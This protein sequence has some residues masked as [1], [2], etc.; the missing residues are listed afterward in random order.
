MHYFENTDRLGEG[1]EALNDNTAVIPLRSKR[2]ER[3]QKKQQKKERKRKSR[4]SLLDLPSELVLEIL[5]FLRPNDVLVLQRVSKNFRAFVG[6][7]EGKI[8]GEIIKWRY[9]VLS[10][11][12]QL[13]VLRDRI[14]ETA[15][16]ALQDME[17]SEMRRRHFQ[18]VLPLDPEI[19]CSCRECSLNWVHLCGVMDFAHWQTNL[20]K[21]D[22]IPIIPRGQFPEW[23]QNLIAEQADLIHKAL[24]SPLWYARILEMH[25]ESTTNSIRRQRENKG[26]KRT[27]FRMSVEDEESETDS[28]LE[29][30]GP[31]SVELIYMRDQYYMLEAYLPNRA[32]SG[33][34]SK[35]VYSISAHNWYLEKAKAEFMRLASLRKQE[36]QPVK[37]D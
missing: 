25:L 19:L 16:S 17:G 29:R 7:Q 10:K 35:W 14:D 11:C 36:T 27:R 6:K 4:M 28:F 9:S 33:Y 26:N 24:Y 18:H 34:H 30:S 32:W 8:A 37:T 31:P 13:P 12:F 15:H 5:S 1:E 22:P 21:G 2:T 3:L 20:D 23:N